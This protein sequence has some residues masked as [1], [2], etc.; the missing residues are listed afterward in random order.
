[1]TW[2]LRVIIAA[3]VALLLVVAIAVIISRPEKPVVLGT[4]DR[5]IAVSADGSRL[6]LG[7]RDKKDKGE[8]KEIGL[9]IEPWTVTGCYV[10]AET[11][12]A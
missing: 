4:L 6:L 8:L 2:W 11:Q 3:A 1:M 5:A 12:S 9:V 10:P 7:M